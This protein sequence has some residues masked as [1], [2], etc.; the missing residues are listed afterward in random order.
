MKQISL[1]NSNSSHRTVRSTGRWQTRPHR[2]R[3]TGRSR[4]CA[5]H[6][7]QLRGPLAQGDHGGQVAQLL[8]HQKALLVALGGGEQRP[9]LLVAVGRLGERVPA[10]GVCPRR[11]VAGGCRGGQAVLR[12]SGTVT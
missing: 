1:L 4:V 8:A 3:G 11:L 5:T 10:L 6:L 2:Q 9:V 12:I 7:V